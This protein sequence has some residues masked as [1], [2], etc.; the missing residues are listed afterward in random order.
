[1]EDEKK[2]KMNKE[3]LEKR[4]SHFY[5]WRG[6]LLIVLNKF[7]K[8]WSTMNGKELYH[9]VNTKML[10]RASKTFSF[11]GPLSTS[12]SYHVARTFATA[13]GM[14]LQVT[15]HFPRLSYC[16]AFDASLISDYPEEQ[17]WLIGFMYLRLLEV[18]TKKLVDDAA[19]FKEICKRINCSSWVREEFFAVHL[20]REMIF[21]M[22]DH[23][24][25]ILAQFLRTNRFECC[26]PVQKIEK[27]E[28][29][30]IQCND[31]DKDVFIQILCNCAMRSTP[32]RDS[33]SKHKN[34]QEKSPCCAY[35]PRKDLDKKMKI[36]PILWNKFNEFRLHPNARQRIKFDLISPHLKRF[37]ME[38]SETDK[39]VKTNE[40]R[41][42]ISFEQ[43][44]CSVLR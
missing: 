44:T 2:G 17:E 33:D 30:S 24:E 35:W 39:N 21:S 25:R 11:N 43:R 19:N 5:H 38:Q 42:N 37:F 3:E 28:R 9:G 16:N 4:L 31:W 27:Y 23:L 26:D 8:T 41:W 12:A 7:G 13:K 6:G 29:Q 15:S 36:V 34:G 10:I 20:F 40:L 18:R 22:S 1:M 32:M 14:V